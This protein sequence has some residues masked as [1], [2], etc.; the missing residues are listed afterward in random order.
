MNKSEK[1]TAENHTKLIQKP[2]GESTDSLATSYNP[3][4]END[5]VKPLRNKSTNLNSKMQ[6]LQSLR[7]KDYNNIRQVLKVPDSKHITEKQA[8]GKI[9]LYDQREKEGSLWNKMSI[10]SQN[11]MNFKMLISRDDESVSSEAQS[12]EP[13]IHLLTN[14]QRKLRALKKP[15]SYDVKNPDKKFSY[16][17]K[18]INRSYHLIRKMGD[19]RG[20]LEVVPTYKVEQNP[21]LSKLL[22][23]LFTKTLLTLSHRLQHQRPI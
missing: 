16:A 7:F 15:I 23:H 10:L 12:Q 13:S 4:S 1:R 14:K 19:P 5:L 17:N 6:K 18:M 20:V 21:H 9:F 11:T 3:D 8:L 2:R 22:F